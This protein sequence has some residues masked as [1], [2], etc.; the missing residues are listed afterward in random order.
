[1]AENET[2]LIDV[3]L[4]VDQVAREASRA[5]A[6]IEELKAQQKA[7]NAEIKA[8]NDIDG[9]MS[10]QL[11]QVTGKLDDEKRALKSAQ[12]VMRAYYKTQKEGGQSLN[13]M[14]QTLADMQKAYA[15]LTAEQREG[16]AGKQFLE[17][18]QAQDAAVKSAEASIGDY[19]R[20]V[21]NY[22]QVV[23]GLI[24]QFAAL[25]N[26]LGKIGVSI[27]NFEGGFVKSMKAAR[28][29]VLS[30]GK[31]FITPPVVVITAVLLAIVAAVKLVKAGF[32]KLKEA[33]A[34]NDEAGTNLAKAMALFKPI[35]QA[36]DKAFD[37]LAKTLGRLLG[38]FADGVA[39][40]TNFFGALISGDPAFESSTSK[41]IKLVEAIDALEEAQRDYVV[42]SAYNNKEI[43]R[44]RDEAADKENLTAEERKKRL[45]DAVALETANLEQQRKIKAEEL[46]IIEETAK[47]ESDTSDATKDKIAKARAEMYQAEEAY[48]S[49]VR[50]LN[51]EIQ[52]LN[53]EIQAEEDARKKEQ[54]EAAK[55]YAEAAKKRADALKEEREKLAERRRTDEENE[56]EALRRQMVEELRIKG[57]TEAEKVEIEQYF[58]QQAANVRER[59][60]KEEEAKDEERYKTK[61]AALVQLGLA[62][63]YELTAAQQQ[64]IDKL[65]E[66]GF[67]NLA[68]QAEANFATLNELAEEAQ[69]SQQE[70]DAA[71][72]LIREQIENEK[73]AITA[74]AAKERE[75]I[76]KAE[77]E[78]MR[79]NYKNS[80]FNIGGAVSSLTSAFG[81]MFGALDDGT[82][83]SAK[84]Q[85]ALALATIITDEAMTIASGAA[86]IA[87]AVEGAT[88]AGAATGVAAPITTPAFVAE[89][90]AIVIT[91]IAGVAAT[92]AKAKNTLSSA[93]SFATGGIVGGNNYSD[94][95]TANVSSREM[96]ITPTQQARLWEVANS[97][98]STAA[99][100][101]MVAA[102]AAAVG[103]LPAPVME[104][105]E[106]KRFEQKTANITEIAKL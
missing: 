86:A 82:E 106:F 38:A 19:R 23:K 76:E 22:G 53:K 25:E 43:A 6:S 51:K 26:A 75:K 105:T 41:A 30:L 64:R 29:G 31:A 78:K 54:Q 28:G 56:I 33:F 90:V 74:K 81:E 94:G 55:R 97:A 13:E 102:L 61:L 103:N 89:L 80:L 77:A 42:T 93:G 48:F 14:R 18:I 70:R 36:I 40:I 8:G 9:E 50:R 34:K 46:R 24:P 73:T 10:R 96:I 58:Q 27:T 12:D 84:K 67:E 7:L 87:N 17:A 99:A 32:D 98:P 69:L 37:G 95:L 66:E 68:E 88:K 91:Q 59:Y 62:K 2:I 63:E 71:D 15:G 83:K 45:Q 52:G 101:G 79:E 21:G 72:L 92:I 3:K 35:S 1:M 65:R 4:D 100:D 11:A 44:L 104:Y 85:K 20:N 16:A 60:R 49:G 39:T 5:A 47:A 57:L